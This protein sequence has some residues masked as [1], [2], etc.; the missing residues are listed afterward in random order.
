MKLLQTSYNK[1]FVHT[2]ATWDLNNKN[3]IFHVFVPFDLQDRQG[4][5][6]KVREALEFLYPG[7]P[8]IGCSATGEI[9]NGIMSD[10]D[11]VVSAMVFETPTS[12]VDV[13]PYYAEKDY[14]EIDELLEMARNT[15]NLKGI[16]LLTAAPY[17][18]LEAAVEIMDKLPDDIEI[19]GAV[20]VGD[21][22]RK[23]FVFANECEYST[24]SSVLVMYIG[25][26]L[27]IQTERMF[28]WKAIGYPLKVTRSEGPVVY[29]LEGKPAFEVYN[30]YLHIHNDNNFFYDALQFPWEVQVDEQTKYVRHAKS[31]NSDGSIVMSTNIPQNADIR[32]TFGDPIRIMNH[33]RQIS[34]DIRKFSPDAVFLINCMGR[35]LFWN[36]NDD[37]EVSEISKNLQTTGFSALGELLRYNGTTLLNN[38]SIVCVAM[39]EGSEKIKNGADEDSAAIS[40]SLSITHRLAIFINTITE[41]LMEKNNQ[42]NEMLYKASHD[43]LTG[44]LNRGAIERRIYDI[45]GTDSDLYN[46]N[47]HLIMLDIDD[48]KALN[49][50]Y[51]HTEG[52]Q[53]LK[54]LADCLKNEICSMPNVEAGRWGGEE[55]MI[56]VIE[57]DDKSVLKIADHIK[58]SINNISCQS[59]NLSVSIG[60]TRHKYEE[61]V[62]RTIDRVDSLLYDAKN[63]GKNKVC[64]DMEQ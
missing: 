12:K 64:S 16:E 49:D 38:L 24:D 1:N 52:D 39:R 35:K 34:S 45:T 9:S 62:L 22:F 31:V 26:D 36:Y 11:I 43:A 61:S 28:G 5:A 37:I 46:K 44:I 33:T 13:F 10:H 17:Q 14:V 23:P 8:V 55:F 25:E 60:A 50:N 54:A 32:I 3:A 19:F 7:I 63:S 40:S 57:K 42:L 29:E 18:S 27:H 4:E 58:S 41:E 20:A 51:G 30:H 47:W 15:P 59:G 21:Q 2:V 56:L 48:F 53:A 6:D